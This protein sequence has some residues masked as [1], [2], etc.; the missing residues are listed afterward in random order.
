MLMLWV[1]VCLAASGCQAAALT[2]R[3]SSALACADGVPHRGSSRMCASA[4]IQLRTATVGSATA[5]TATFSVAVA[6]ATSDVGPPTPPILV[7][8]PIGVGIDRTICG[9]LLEAWTR[10]P[11]TSALHC[12]DVIGM[13]DSTKRPMSAPPL[14]PREWAEQL[15]GYAKSLGQPVIV[16]GQSN[17]CTVALEMVALQNESQPE[18]ADAQPTLAALVLVGPPAIEAISAQKSDEEINKVWRVVSSPL[19]AL[20]FRFARR[21]R[22]LESFSK[23]NLFADPSQVDGDY[24]DI[25]T[26][27]AQET[28]TR[29]AVFSF[30][31]GTW[32]N[33]YRPLLAQLELPV[34]VVSGRDV[35]ASGGTSQDKGKR[36][37]RTSTLNLLKW[38]GK[39]GGR[40]EQ[41]GRDLGADPTKKLDEWASAMPNAR[42]ETRLTSGW[43]V[44]VYEIPVEL[45]RLLDA[46]AYKVKQ[47]CE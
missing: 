1:C 12:A 13:G 35:K 44:L 6:P 17:L 36:V 18:S 3:F 34:L 24:L 4:A 46:Y 16:V 42:V 19:G 28:A 2:G 15:M 40:F 21:R 22:F 7:I 47:F 39:R 43:N 45:S 30:V 9:P 23:K 27:G 5:G 14:R 33:D 20:L 25:C 26:R 31:S 41:V 10:E 29:H 32:R 38:F 11:R 37:D 8:P